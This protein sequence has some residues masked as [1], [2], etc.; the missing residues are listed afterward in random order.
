[1]LKYPSIY[2]FTPHLKKV[3]WTVQEIEQ[4]QKIT[5]LN[6]T[7]NKKIKWD[8]VALYVQTRTASQCR[9][10]YANVLK[11]TLDTQMRQNHNWNRCEIM[12]LWTFCIAFDKDFSFVQ[13]NY[14]PKFTVKQISSQFAQVQ[15]KQQI[16]VQVFRS[17]LADGDYIQSLADSDFKMQL[18]ILRA[19]NRRLT[20]I[21]VKLLG[22]SNEDVPET[23][24]QV[25][26]TEIRALDV[27]FEDVDIRSALQVYEAEE[28]RRGITEPFYIPTQKV[29]F[30]AS[31]DKKK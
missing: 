17:V 18:W 14:M 19:A 6:R 30:R 13:K 21:D 11:K 26:Y 4:L 8:L 23:Q 27:F 29:N 24:Y 15:K 3:A 1:M 20:M 7:T 28:A 31:D 12:A 9:S 10:Y 2:Q 5:E 22:K 16:M 25:D